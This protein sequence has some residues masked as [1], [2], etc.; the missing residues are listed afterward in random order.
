M[1]STLMNRSKW[2]NNKTLLVLLH[3]MVWGTLFGFPFLL[4][5]GQQPA[6]YKIMQHSWIPLV[7]YMLIFYCNYVFL[8]ER[9]LFRK[10]LWT[11]ILVNLV[12]SVG[13]VFAIVFVRILFFRMD[14]HANRP[15]PLPWQ[16]FFYLEFLSML[17]PLFFSIAMRIS[18][19]WIKARADEQEQAA[20]RFQSELQHLKYQLQ[21][22][23]FFNALN[24]IYALVDHS[25][26]KAKETIH[27]LGKLMRYF[28]HETTTQEV[29]LAKEIDFM[30][31]YIELMEIRTADRVKVFVD[32]PEV[33][34]EIR[35]A[36]LLFISLIE[37][38]F[39]HG[40]ASTEIAPMFFHMQL[41]DERLLFT[42]RN[43]YLPKTLSDQSGSGI[44]LV[45]LEKR[46]QLLYPEHHHF[47]TRI[48][49]DQF[50]TELEIHLEG[51]RNED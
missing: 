36:P 41:T 9:L 21:P 44:G 24:N 16:F 51:L 2:S 7:A 18:G 15:P 50:I 38:A 14:E 42:S 28:L 40:V 47:V 8:I 12:L 6:M 31:K 33:K 49:N 39:K 43:A 27:S 25:P 11:Y 34:P 48:E 45:N 3:I 13:L 32:F 17:I 20:F 22:H 30:R 10:R 29:Q 19:R 46:L 5:Y 4:T 35:I 23:F 37:N 1:N 26:E